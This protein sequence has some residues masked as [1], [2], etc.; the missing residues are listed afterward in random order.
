MQLEVA[1]LEQKVN[2]YGNYFGN[3]SYNDLFL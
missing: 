1:L 3:C 2:V